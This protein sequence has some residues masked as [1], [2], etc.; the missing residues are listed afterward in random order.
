MT[1]DER[2]VVFKL[3]GSLLSLPDLPQ[4]LERLRSPSPM[5][6]PLIVVGGGAAADL[7]RDWQTV[8]SLS[9]ELAH[10]LAI[11]AMSFNEALLHK[12]L[13]HSAVVRDRGEIHS[14]WN[15]RLLPILSAEGFL[16]AEEETGDHSLPHDWSATSDS[17]AAWVA[18][19]LGGRALTLLKSLDL[20]TG[21]SLEEAAEEGLV[22]TH[23]PLVA[24]RLAVSWINVRSD[25]RPVV[26][27]TSEAT[28]SD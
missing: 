18:Q 3:G 19:R 2:T 11:R 5:G 28:A 8:H 14:A 7:V 17:I 20:P 26:E 10:W 25:S 15:A 21:I 9:D 23:F 1:A 27:W 22:D 16:Q 4:Q 12:L 24:A 6:R 13:P